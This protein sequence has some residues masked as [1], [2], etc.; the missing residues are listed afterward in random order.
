[1]TSNIDEVGTKNARESSTKVIKKYEYNNTQART[2]TQYIF[3]F[4]PHNNYCYF[5]LKKTVLAV[6][7]SRVRRGW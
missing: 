5:L 1:M 3:S 6:K 2:Y 4:T 7:L